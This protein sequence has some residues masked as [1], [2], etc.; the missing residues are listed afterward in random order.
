VVEEDFLGTTFV[1]DLINQ[2]DKKMKIKR[3]LFIRNL[4]KKIS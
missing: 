2:K 3:G 4:T 1:V